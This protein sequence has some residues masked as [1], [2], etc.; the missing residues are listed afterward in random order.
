MVIISYSTIKNYI[1]E[2]NCNDIIC[3]GFENWMRIMQS[4]DFANLNELRQI[5]N[6]VDFVGNDRYVF[7]V[8]GNNYRLI[9]MIHFSVRTVY[10]LFLG[11]HKEYNKVDAK[12]VTYKIF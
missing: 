1:K 2:K 6:H 3:D 12:N 7:N 5:F 4:N 9:A 10:I 11:T 8:L